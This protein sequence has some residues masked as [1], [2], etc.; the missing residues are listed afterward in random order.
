DR[1]TARRF[2]EITLGGSLDTIR[3]AAEVDAIEI[4][5]EDLALAQADF[6]PERHHRLLELAA[7][8]AL[9]RKKEIFGELLGE[10]GAALHGAAGPKVRQ[11][12]PD[13]PD[14]IEAPVGEEAAILDGNDGIYEM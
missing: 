4:K 13:E 7:Q 1:D 6:E 9:G 5:L 8:G 3:A 11:R 2:S 10:G 14:R 12:G